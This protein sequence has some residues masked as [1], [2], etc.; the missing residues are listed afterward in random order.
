MPLDFDALDH[1][2]FMREALKEAEVSLREGERP[3]GAVIVH[4]GKIVGRGRALHKKRHS[5]IAHAEMNALIQAE[6]YLDEYQ[7]EAVLYTT[8]EPCV[9]C[10]GAVVMSDLAGVVFALP[11]H[12]IMPAQM[13]EMPYVR[14]HIRHYLGGV[15][16]QESEAL[17]LKSAHA[18]EISFLLG[19]GQ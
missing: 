14:R 13:L 12:N 2:K 5:Q 19:S 10:F 9:M 18:K 4:G 11:D 3:I 8:V 16:Q 1:Q 15:L 6:R 17:W 7:H